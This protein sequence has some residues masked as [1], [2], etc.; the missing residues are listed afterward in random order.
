MFFHQWGKNFSQDLPFCFIWPELITWLLLDACKGD[1]G[2]R[3][4]QDSHD[5]LKTYFNSSPFGTGFKSK[6]G[7]SFSQEENGEW[8]LLGRLQTGSSMPSWYKVFWMFSFDFR[9]LKKKQLGEGC[10]SLVDQK[11]F[12][13]SLVLLSSVYTLVVFFV[14]VFL[15]P[16]WVPILS[17]LTWNK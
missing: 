11:G 9:G 14:C 4:V 16:G 10:K 5:G 6:F 2:K 3:V 7:G 1:L 17:Y 15:P 12:C 8:L 13:D